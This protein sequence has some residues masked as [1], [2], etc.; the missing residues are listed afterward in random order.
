HL[1]DRTLKRG[2]SGNDVKELQDRLNELHYNVVVTAVFDGRTRNRVKR[3]QV[4]QGSPKTGVVGRRTVK[5]LRSASR[6]DPAGW[7]DWVFP[8]TPIKRVAPETWWSNDQGVDIP[9]I[10]G[11]CGPDAPEVAVT[12]GT[13]VQIGISGFGQWAPIIKVDNGVYKG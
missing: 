6:A 13:V 3:F 11:A 7:A 4:D 1:G 2:M 8:I 9:T 10:N 5:A 12:S